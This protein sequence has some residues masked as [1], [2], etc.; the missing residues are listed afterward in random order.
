MP[1]AYVGTATAGGTGAY[2][3]TP[4]SPLADGTYALRVRAVDAAGNVGAAG[5]AFN[6]TITTTTTTAP[7]TPSTPSL[8]SAD[9]S[10]PKGDLITNARQPRLVGTA[11]PGL[12]VQIVIGG[13]TV[14]GSAPVAPDGS[15]SVQVSY[16]LADGT[17]VFQ[18]RGVDDQGNQSAL[19]AGLSL[20]VDTTPPLAPASFRLLDADDSGV[21]GDGTTYVRQPRLVGTA[22]PGASL[23]LFSGTAAQVA[24]GQAAFIGTGTVAGDGTFT[25]SPS[26]PLADGSYVLTIRPRRLGQRGAARVA[27]F[28]CGS[29]RPARHPG[30]PRVAGGRRQRSRRGRRHPDQ[31]AEVHRHD[32]ARARRSSS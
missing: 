30:R 17:Y 16:E 3:V 31:A 20:T 22:E 23:Q 29:T 25:I 15:Y 14:L 1:R 26:S 4:A 5:P 28:P 9:D 6:L 32:R 13:G 7:A 18:A 24:A 2:V 8:L 21:K 12:T 19:S 27:G 10:G 11:T